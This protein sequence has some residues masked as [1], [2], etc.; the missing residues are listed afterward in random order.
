[1]NKPKA[2]FVDD[3]SHILN[4]LRR[5]LHGKMPGWDLEFVESGVEALANLAERPA[6]V[7]VTDMRMP[8]MDG[9][10]LLNEVRR[11]YPR[12]IRIILSGY[13]GAE[14]IYRTIGPAHQYYAKPC[15]PDVLV[16]A[17]SRAMAL[18][19]LIHSEALLT[20]IGSASTVPVLPKT[21]IRLLDEI[22][23]PDASVGAIAKII[24]G[25]IGLTTQIMKLTNSAYFAIPQQVSTPIQAVRLLGLETIRALALMAGI[26]EAFA[27]SGIDLDAIEL[28]EGRCLGIGAAAKEIAL[29][30]NLGLE[31]ADRAQCAGMLSHVGS[32][33]MQANW[34]ESIAKVRAALSCNRGSVT[35]LELHEFGASHAEIGAY[36]LGIWGFSDEVVEAVAFHHAPSD[37]RA[38]AGATPGVLT[39]LHVAQHF[40]KPQPVGE[41]ALA[42][43]LG[44]VDQ[45]YLERLGLS[46]NIAGWVALC[47]KYEKGVRP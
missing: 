32:I 12:T 35:E 10:S 39:C 14:A 25:D 7:V 46:G 3:E 41:E 33:L 23:S 22:Q 40:V 28:L 19:K 4:G 17:I 44:S 29:S 43:W 45:V 16:H 1:M 47:R 6:D 37:E 21:L 2:L 30:L 42:N 5:M 26:F 31:L 9:A 18:R 27:K 34:P 8:R 38:F 24:E 11:K 36:L 15:P 20:L 13:S